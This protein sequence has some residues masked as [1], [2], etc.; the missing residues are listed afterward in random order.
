MM[1]HSISGGETRLE[2]EARQLLVRLNSGRALAEDHE[3]ATRW[4]AQSAEHEQA[5]RQMEDVWR[6]L[7]DL[8]TSA[9]DANT[10]AV[11]RKRRKQPWLGA[12]AASIV[13]AAILGWMATPV[14]GVASLTADERTSAGELRAVEL[15]DGSEVTL[16]GGSAANWQVSTSERQVELVAGEAYFQVAHDTTRPFH[17]AAG[18]AHIQ[19]T[20]TAFAVKRLDNAV[21]L[22]VSQGHV[23]ASLRDGTKEVALTAGQSVTWSDDE[24]S[25]VG[26]INAEEATAWLR[27][28]L[29]VRDARLADIATELT[30]YRSGRILLLG[31]RARDV[32]VTGVFDVS[33]PDRILAT[34]E[35]TQGVRVY[36]VGSLLTVI[37]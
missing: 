8:G 36:R 27:G 35:Q 3:A 25:G 15:N 14:G 13:G 37:R 22:T 32:Q 4:R 24:M 12:V 33:D 19:V 29:I 23:V 9:E 31:E 16:N 20:G 34:I 21:I 26:T 28:R 7:G 2:A 18:P 11:E 10:R 1:S 17:V 5:F 6:M 30:R